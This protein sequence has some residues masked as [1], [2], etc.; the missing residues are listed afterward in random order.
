MITIR[1]AA[2]ADLELL[3]RIRLE[4]LRDVNDLGDGEGFAEELVGES[5][6]YFANGD[7]TTVLAFDGECAIGCASMSYYRIMPTFAH[8]T[9]RRAHL[10]NVYV[11]EAYRRQ[12]IARKMIES[13]IEDAKIMGATEISLDATEEGRP[14]YESLGFAA[15]EE[16]MV[17]NI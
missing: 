16:C 1:K 10:M 11:R 3:M 14:L 5:R 6:E 17:M 12:G 9:G 15:S 8:P 7:Q 4:M 2:A 13:L